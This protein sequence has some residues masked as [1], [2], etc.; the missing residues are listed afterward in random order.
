MSRAVLAVVMNG[1]T[2]PIR[3]VHWRATWCSRVASWR[4]PPGSGQGRMVWIM[5]V[6]LPSPQVTGRCGRPRGGRS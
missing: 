1:M 2:V 3:V 4:T 6:R 5:V